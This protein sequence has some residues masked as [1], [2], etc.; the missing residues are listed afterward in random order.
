[1]INLLPPETKEAYRYA[2]INTRLVRWI[3][4]F[5]FAFIGLA[6]ISVFGIFYLH[7]TAKSYDGQVAAMADSLRKQN[8]AQTNKE[9]KE[10]GDNLKLAV[11]VLSK[12]VLYSQ[13]LK[14][15][16]TAI[17]NNVVLANLNLSQVQGALDITADVTDY[18]AAT[19]LQV[20]L[21][22][23]KN[24]IFTK[25][26]IVSI[27]CNQGGDSNSTAPKPYPCSVTVRALFGQN[28]PFLFIS[29]NKGAKQ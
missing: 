28:N 7:Q 22:D 6:V 1:V 2:R 9:V 23:P 10:I 29:Q 25:A 3:F 14:Q 21:A 11:G 19:Q 8:Q 27:S 4:T 24:R 5:C 26:D 18:D 16:A 17:P 13:L 15:L 20:N 12:E